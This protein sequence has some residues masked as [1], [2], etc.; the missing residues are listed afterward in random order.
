MRRRRCSCLCRW[1]GGHHCGEGGGGVI[2]ECQG[3]EGRGI[4]CN[5]R[6]LGNS[7]REKVNGG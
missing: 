4:V 6:K 2:R 3:G 7:N 5:L 1:F